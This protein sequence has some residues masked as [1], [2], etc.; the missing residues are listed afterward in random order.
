MMALFLLLALACA[1]ALIGGRLARGSTPEI[2]RRS[3][4][5]STAVLERVP[6]NETLQWVLIRSENVANPVV[7]FLHGGPGTSELTLNR[8]NTRELEK[9][10]TVVNWDQRGAG[11]SFAAGRD[12]RGMN[13]N[14]FVDDVID[15]SSYLAER[16][17]QDRILLVG[18]SW[19]SALGLLTVHR[20]PDLFAAYVGIGQASHQAEG[21]R[22][23]YDWTLEQ[24]EKAKDSTSVRKLKEI[25]PPPYTGSNWRSKFMTQR[26]LLGKFGGEYHKSKIGALGVVLKSLICSPEYT[27][28]DRLNYFR[29]IFHS[30]DTVMPQVFQLDL[31]EQVAEVAIPVYFCLGRHDYEV[32]A[33]LSARYFEHLKAPHKELLWFEESAHMPNTEESEKFNAFIVG[34]VVP[35][36]S[37]RVRGTA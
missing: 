4:P 22:L 9:H 17:E 12:T 25:G 8:R 21:E 2:N 14:Q 24:A 6:V 33:E 5:N 34:T 19:G 18:H 30:L 20:R 16:F 7:L 32:P 23:S 1:F 13:V 15:L 28:L 10:L 35:A 37:G 36:I 3:H 31:F 29:G 26:R 27:I 11:K